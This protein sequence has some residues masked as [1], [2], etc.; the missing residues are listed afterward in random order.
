[1]TTRLTRLITRFVREER[2]AVVIDYIPVFIALTILVLLIIEIG[3]AHFLLLRSQKAAQLGAR[4]AATLPAAAAGVPT[5]NVPAGGGTGGFNVP[6]YNAAGGG[7]ADDNCTDPGGPWTCTGTVCDS[8]VMDVIVRDM[9]RTSPE[10][11]ADDV[12][13]TYVYRRLGYAGGPFV[14]EINVSIRKFQYDFA[15]LSLGDGKPED[16]D[17]GSGSVAH[18]E[19]QADFVEHDATVYSAVSASA[20]GENMQ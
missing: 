1:M 17:S 6:C 8:G 13:L 10:I 18:F 16:L 7:I 12:T 2:G 9:Q 14:P 3:I 4:V 20:F 11:S 15:L 5:T 19:L